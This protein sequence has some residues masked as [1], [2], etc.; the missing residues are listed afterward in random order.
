MSNRIQLKGAGRYEEAN[1]SGAVSPGFLL[2]LTAA[3]AVIAH[4]VEGGIGERLFALEDALQG[5]GLD[6]DYADGDLVPYLIA[7]PGD[8]V[9]AFVK[10]GENISIGDQLVSAGDGTLISSASVGS[11]VT[12]DQVIGVAVEAVDLQA[13]GSVNTRIAVRVL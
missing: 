7:N 4:N 13:S 8:E 5:N 9:Y 12:V 1:A 3:G 2:A 11:G 10:A 6:T